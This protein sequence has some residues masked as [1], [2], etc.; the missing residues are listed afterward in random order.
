MSLFL[1]SSFPFPLCACSIFAKD[2]YVLLKI[3]VTY[4]EK[5]RF[6]NLLLNLYPL[7]Y[8]YLDDEKCFIKFKTHSR[9]K[10]EFFYFLGVVLNF[11]IKLVKLPQFCLADKT[12]VS[13]IELKKLFSQFLIFFLHLLRAM[14]FYLLICQKYYFF[15]YVNGFFGLF[16]AFYRVCFALPLRCRLFITEKWRKYLWDFCYCVSP[17]YAFVIPSM[18]SFKK[19]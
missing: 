13:I 2:I 8:V 18:F 7:F 14:L 10:N 17:H 4:F 16:T 6:T 11:W 3:I 1:V 5:K 12:F 15:R 9:R 19:S